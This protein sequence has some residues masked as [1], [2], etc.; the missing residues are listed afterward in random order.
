MGRWRR[1]PG[2]A[3]GRSVAGSGRRPRQGLRCRRDG[4]G[5]R[6]AQVR[7]DR[8]G[9]RIRAG[10]GSAAAFEPVPTRGLVNGS[11]LSGAAPQPD[12]AEDGTPTRGRTRMPDADAIG[13]VAGTGSAVSSGPELMVTGLVAAFRAAGEHLGAVRFGEFGRTDG[14]EFTLRL[15][16]P[17]GPGR[18]GTPQAA[19]LRLAG[20]PRP[21]RRRGADRPSATNVASTANTN[22]QT[23]TPI[24][25]W[26]F[27]LS[28]GVGGPAGT[29]TTE[30]IIAEGSTEAWVW[31]WAS[32][33]SENL[34]R[35]PTDSLTCAGSV[36]ITVRVMKGPSALA[37]SSAEYASVTPSVASCC[38]ESGASTRRVRK[39]AMSLS[40]ASKDR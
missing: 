18:I 32:S 6:N 2:R 16:I 7:G 1:A 25:A 22:P 4:R 14:R 37:A 34:S 23:P 8:F 13:T 11:V 31:I 30:P 12:G 9:I 21:R 20:P 40:E 33:C 36:P 27:D 5:R 17:R 19:A 15:Q 38:A 26:I 24:T 10:P 35:V 39:S 3:R 29:I 28:C